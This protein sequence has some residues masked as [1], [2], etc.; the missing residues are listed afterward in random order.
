[1]LCYVVYN[2]YLYCCARPQECAHSAGLRVTTTRTWWKYSEHPSCSFGPEAQRQAR[3]EAPGG[4][5]RSWLWMEQPAGR[6]GRA[7]LPGLCLR[8]PN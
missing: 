7:L 6:Q 5:T 3:C 8:V 1:M 2:I 4:D